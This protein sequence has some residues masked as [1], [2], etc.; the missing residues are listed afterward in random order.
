MKGHEP[1]E[2]FD[3][4]KKCTKPWVGR[5]RYI[6][7]RRAE[8]IGVEGHIRESGLLLRS[9]PQALAQHLLH[10][11]EQGVGSL[12]RRLCIRARAEQRHQTRRGWTVG[13]LSGG[14]GKPTLNFRRPFRVRGMPTRQPVFGREI[15]QN[16]VG[17][18]DDGP[19]II[20]QHGDLT[21]RIPRQELRPLLFSLEE[22]DNLCLDGNARQRKKQN[23]AMRMTG[24]GMDI[25]LHFLLHAQFGNGC[26]PR[27][28]S[29]ELRKV[30][31]S[32]FA[33]AVR[34]A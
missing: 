3:S 2:F 1:R 30:E 23:D 24:E 29:M 21:E 20:D 27:G 10:H 17:I 18:G 31:R 22:I 9:Q 19:V 28:S 25:E 33:R 16:S 12:N 15:D 13:Q 8:S 32:D 7:F 14:N 5:Q 34:S 6:P 4:L 11:G 26:R